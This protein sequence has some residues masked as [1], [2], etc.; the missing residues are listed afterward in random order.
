M[1][2]VILMPKQ[3]FNDFFHSFL[4]GGKF[5]YFYVFLFPR[6]LT[7]INRYFFDSSAQGNLS[8]A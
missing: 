1:I 8:H 2:S 5:L 4:Y 6:S 3:T 7:C